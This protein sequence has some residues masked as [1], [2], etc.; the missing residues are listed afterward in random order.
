MEYLIAALLIVG[1]TTIAIALNL[2]A[3]ELYDCAPSFAR[4]LIDCALTR[5]PESERER[6]REEWYADNDGWPGGKLGKVK[7]AVGCWLGAK[8]VGRVVIGPTPKI[9]RYVEQRRKDFENQN[10]YLSANDPK[11]WLIAIEDEPDEVKKI[12]AL[13]CQD[14]ARRSEHYQHL[15]DKFF[16]RLEQLSDDFNSDGDVIDAFLQWLSRRKSSSGDEEE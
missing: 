10:S 7:H 9:N 1:S 14:R 2:I 13:S 3:N 6:C 11:E 5:L 4:W 15:G 8:A 16:T 12:V